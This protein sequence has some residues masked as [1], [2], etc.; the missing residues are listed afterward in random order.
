MRRI[1]VVI[2][3]RPSYSRIKTALEAIEAH[4]DLELQLVV[5]ASA[6]LDRFGQRRRPHRGGRLPHRRACPDGARRRD[7]A[8]DGEDDRRGH[9]RARRCVR[10]TR[11]GRGRDRRRPLRDAR[12]RDRCR[13]PRHPARARP[14]RRGDRLDRRA[15]PPRHHEARRPPP[16]V[17]RARS[18][19][20]RAH[21]RGP[22][23]IVVTGCPSIDLARRVIEG[24]S[25][26]FD[27]YERYVG[28][29]ERPTS[30]TAT[31]SSCST[32]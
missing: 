17:D 9:H 21:G 12:D 3:A 16:A 32:R 1:C 23:R 8:R 18:R 14:G 19:P 13:L 31:S 15:R 4:P 22:E 27:P 25:P 29:G 5:A 24:D 26:S 7:A 28:V 30:P 20:H 11:A 6:L 2:T 10:P